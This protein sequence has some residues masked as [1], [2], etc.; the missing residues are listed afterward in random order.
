MPMTPTSG[1]SQPEPPDPAATVEWHPNQAD[2]PGPTPAPERAEEVVTASWWPVESATPARAAGTGEAPTSRAPAPGAPE[3]AHHAPAG[4]GVAT[5]PGA[6]GGP[7]WTGGTAHPTTPGVAHAAEIVISDRPGQRPWPLR[8][9]AV[10]AALI[11]LV[12]SGSALQSYRN[13]RAWE[14]RAVVAERQV[15]TLSEQLEKSESAVGS[16]TD[17]TRD[18][19]D[20]KAKAED[21]REALRLYARKH[22][23]LTRAAGGVSQQL[24]AC[25]EQLAGSSGMASWQLE[26]TVADCREALADYQTLQSLIDSMPATPEAGEGEE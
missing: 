16:L 23:E 9:A 4:P 14:S 25:I 11:T 8:V 18:L 19:A 26:Q 6:P 22:A 24:T 13:G 20:E 12:A 10:L 5:A 15:V 3:T 2:Q 21:E 1:S 17:R 7:G